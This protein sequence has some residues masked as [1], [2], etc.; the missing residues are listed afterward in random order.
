MME[1]GYWISAGRIYGP[2]G[3]TGYVIRSDH[4]IVGRRGYTRHWIYRDQIYSQNQGNTGYRVQESRILGPNPEP[5]WEQIQ[6]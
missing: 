2:V 6:H 5:P 4:R 1:T 3:F